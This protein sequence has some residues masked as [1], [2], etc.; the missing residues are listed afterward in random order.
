[1][2]DE[3]ATCHDLRFKIDEFRFCRMCLVGFGLGGKE[4]EQVKF[5]EFPMFAKQTERIPVG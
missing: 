3:P 4:F 5:D 2:R 1:M